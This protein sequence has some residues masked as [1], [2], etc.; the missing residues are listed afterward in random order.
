MYNFQTGRKKKVR[1]KKQGMMGEG[2]RHRG[3]G[4]LGAPTA[5]EQPSGEEVKSQG[6]ECLISFKN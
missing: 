3:P 5:G 1:L 2:E 6:S 4:S